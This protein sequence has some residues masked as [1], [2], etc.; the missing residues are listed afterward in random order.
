MGEGSGWEEGGGG[1]VGER[2][3][4]GLEGILGIVG[5]GKEGD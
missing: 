4:A 2:E 5:E 3:R 1:C